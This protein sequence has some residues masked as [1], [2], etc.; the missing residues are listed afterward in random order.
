M[1][2]GLTITPN[3][4]IWPWPLPPCHNN[5]HTHN[6][7]LTSSSTRTPCPPR[8]LTQTRRP[9]RRPPRTHRRPLSRDPMAA[10]IPP[11]SQTQEMRL[12][13]PRCWLCRTLCTRRL[14]RPCMP[15]LLLVQRSPL[16]L[17]HLLL[18]LLLPESLLLLL[19]PVFLLRLSLLSVILLCCLAHRVVAT[20]SCL[21]AR[22]SHSHRRNRSQHSRNTRW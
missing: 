16:L 8:P 3:R 18:L 20:I 4:L 9:L 19:L 1:P 7:S 17:L 11:D 5:K 10:A 2:S 21:L 12:T 15:L 22:P 13:H 6:T 14:P